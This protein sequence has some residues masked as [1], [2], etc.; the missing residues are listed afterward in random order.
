MC[1]GTTQHNIA[2]HRTSG[3]RGGSGRRLTPP[4][5]VVAQRGLALARSQR[6]A[7]ENGKAGAPD[8]Q[9][10]DPENCGFGASRFLLSRVEF[11][12]GFLVN[13]DAHQ[14]HSVCE[15]RPPRG[16]R[17]AA[18][19]SESDS[20]SFASSSGGLGGEPR[21]KRC[22]RL[23]ASHRPS[24]RQNGTLEFITSASRYQDELFR[25]LPLRRELPQALIAFAARVCCR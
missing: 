20:R 10:E 14:A 23:Q 22:Y 19:R 5:R 24:K 16:P 8:A 6:P 18:G 15:E 17:K 11:H 21:N 3:R 7:S 13:M 12:T 9:S 25:R 4:L 2:Q 1:H